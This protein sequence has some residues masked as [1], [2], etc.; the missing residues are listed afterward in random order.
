VSIKAVAFDIDG[1]L[2]PERALNARLASFAARNAR[3]LFAFSSARRRLHA[4]DETRGDWPDDLAGFRR[5]QAEL[6]AERLKLSE[7]EAAALADRIIYEELD[8]YFAGLPVFG[9]LER[10]LDDLASGDLRLAVLSDFPTE[11]K[12]KHLGLAGR[13]ELAQCSE[14]SG[15]L[16]PAA[17]PFLRLAGALGLAPE[18]ILYVGNSRRYDVR[19]SR[20]AGMKSALLSSARRR[21]DEADLVFRRWGELARFA[22]SP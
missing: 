15:L 5:L 4:L 17:R 22:L 3:F 21:G 10:A 11:R 2:Y 6:V 20:A 19:G 8:S 13:F 16:K 14:G 1:T 12:L 18:E 7:A 9:G